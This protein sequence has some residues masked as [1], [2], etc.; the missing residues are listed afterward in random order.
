MESPKFYD[1]KRPAMTQVRMMEVG[2]TLL[3]PNTKYQMIAC[4]LPIYATSLN[5]RWK[6]HKLT[7]E[8]WFELTRIR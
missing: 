1:S 7:N 5:M 3:F 8:P 6:T 4:N 2:D